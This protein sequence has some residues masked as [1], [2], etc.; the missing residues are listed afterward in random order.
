VAI[1][2]PPKATLRSVRVRAACIENQS[3]RIKRIA[4]A[5]LVE[6]YREPPAL[7]Y[8]KGRRKRLSY[9]DAGIFRISFVDV[10]RL[11]A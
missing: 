1:C 3:I 8:S 6:V 10:N 11:L 4:C 5:E 7:R 2:Q 9:T